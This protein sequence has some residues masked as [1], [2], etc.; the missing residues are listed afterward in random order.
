MFVNDKEAIGK[1]EYYGILKS[2]TVFDPNMAREEFNGIGIKEIYFLPNGGK[3]WIFEG[4][5]KGVLYI[6]Y[7]GDAPV[8]SCKYEI[9]DAKQMKFMLLELTEADGSVITEVLIKTSSKEFKVSDFAKKD[10]I[11]I[12]F[13]HD[14]KIIGKWKSVGF[15]QNIDD[16]DGGES[17]EMLWLKSV[18][19]YDSGEAI[20]EYF[21][22]T[23]KDIWTKGFMIDKVKSTL[24]AYSFKEIMGQEYM[25]L[26]WKMGNYCYGG[27]EPAYYVFVRQI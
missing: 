26:Q 9:I 1:W 24:S 6:H 3:Y 18:A 2:S 17:K 5:T 11:D 27:A 8:L 12:P 14:P 10:N 20:R 23:M 4:W 16:F 13:A 7:G 25:F 21:D 19:F 22:D 15:V